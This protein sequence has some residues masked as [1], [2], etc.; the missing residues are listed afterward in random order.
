MFSLAMN[1]VLTDHPLVVHAVNLWNVTR[2]G[3]RENRLRETP[4]IPP[5]DDIWLKFIQK[6]DK[7]PGLHKLPPGHGQRIKIPRRPRTEIKVVQY[8]LNHYPCDLLTIGLVKLF[9]SR[10]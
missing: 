9:C 4:H 7:P 5:I 2:S 10:G 1:A 3:N 6:L 8:S